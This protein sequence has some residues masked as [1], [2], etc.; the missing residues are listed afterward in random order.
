MKRSISLIVA[1]CTFSI[2]ALAQ[3]G[4]IQKNVDKQ[5]VDSKHKQFIYTVSP[6]NKTLDERLIENRLAFEAVL[7]KQPD[8]L[9]STTTDTSWSYSENK[10]F[11]DTMFIPGGYSHYF[12][13]TDSTGNQIT[14]FDQFIWQ[15]DS[16][17]WVPS[18]IQRSFASEDHFDSAYTY[19]YRS[20]EEQPYTGTKSLYPKNPAENAD[21]EVI[22]Q[23][24]EPSNGWIPSS[25]TLSYRDENDWDTL[26]IE[27]VYDR[28]SLDYYLNYRYR[29]Q[30]TENYLMYEYSYFNRRGLSSQNRSEDTPEYAL[31][32]NKSY[33]W[34]GNLSYWQWEYLKKLTNGAWDY[35]VAKVYDPTEM[36]LMNE[37]STQYVYSQDNSEIESRYYFWDDSVWIFDQLYKSFQTE[38]AENNFRVDSIIIYDVDFNEETM[39]YEAGRPRIKTVMQYDADGNQVVVENHTLVNDSLQLTNKTMRTFALINEYPT[40]IKQ[41]SY[42]LDHSSSML[43]RNSVSETKYN[44]NAYAGNSYFNFN[45]AGDTT[46]GYITQYEPL[47]DGSYADVRFDWDWQLKKVV[48]RSYRINGRQITGDD[49]AKYNQYMNATIN[50]QDGTQAIN[51]SMNGY[52]QYPGVFNDGPIYIEMGDTLSL[53]VSA[54]NPDMSIPEVE[55]LNLPSTAT[56]DAETRNIYWVVDDLNPSPMTYKA[57]RGEL[58]VSTEVEFINENFSVG[59]EESASPYDF[60]LSQNYPNPFNPSTNINFTL[61]EAS[62][63]SLKVYNVLGQEVAALVD[64]RMGSGAHSITFDAS[65]LSSGVYIYRLQAGNNVQTKKMLLVK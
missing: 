13:E 44:G 7:K 22:W 56:F 47:P 3:S 8:V 4:P 20:F 33:D 26:S 29:F 65:N 30:Q 17:R 1:F 15:P 54:R 53:F 42:V 36:M 6:I 40:M 45:A 2:V 11:A 10:S 46:Y 37:D 39:Q 24:Y 41:E 57:I 49:G 12:N 27:Y 16:N 55:V 32:Q 31:A 60:D 25:R 50:P 52:N 23:L 21:Y 38:V 28:D 35:Q 14:T 9:A 59:A 61:P 58:S 19:Y 18:R 63:V 48:L 34:E 5:Y 51:R 64:Q 43:Y 62:I